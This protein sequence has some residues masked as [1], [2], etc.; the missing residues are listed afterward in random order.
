MGH[1]ALLGKDSLDGF[2]FFLLT[3]IS[4]IKL[5]FNKSTFLGYCIDVIFIYLSINLQSTSKQL[6]YLAHIK[7]I[8]LTV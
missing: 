2:S 1:N 3:M 5:F 6:S 4:K 8:K 7:K